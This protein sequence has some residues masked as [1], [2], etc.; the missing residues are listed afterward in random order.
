MI[1]YITLLCFLFVSNI[2]VAQNDSMYHNIA[3][4]AIENLNVYQ[5]SSSF[6][7]ESKIDDFY[8]LF[9]NNQVQVVNDILHLNEANSSISLKEYINIIRRNYKR[10]NVSISINEIGQIEYSNESSGTFDVYVTKEI[11]GENINR[12]YQVLI[13]D[14]TDEYDERILY[15]KKL[16]LVFTFHFNKDKMEIIKISN[17]QKVNPT[18]IILP[19][20]RY[21]IF[22]KKYNTEDL[23]VLVDSDT[24]L[25]QGLFHSLDLNK[26]T[27][28]ITPVHD[29]LFGK[30]TVKQAE[31]LRS[32]NKVRELIFK[33]SSIESSNIFGYNFNPIKVFSESINLNLQNNNSYSI[34]S[35][36]RFNLTNILMSKSRF[37]SI[38]ID[39]KPVS[40]ISVFLD[41]GYKL[42]FFSHQITVDNYDYSYMS[43]DD[44][45]A[46]YLRLININSLVEQQEIE[47]SSMEASVLLKYKY[48]KFNFLVGAGLGNVTVDKANF[49]SIASINYSGYYEDFYGLIIAENGVYDFGAYQVEQSGGIDSYKSIQTNSFKFNVEYE[50]NKRLFVN[51]GINYQTSKSGYFKKNNINPSESYLN[52]NTIANNIDYTLNYFS[53]SVGLIIK[54]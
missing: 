13:N 19:K 39:G 30:R 48:E 8:D 12:D 52:L 35:S 15:K 31:I 36:I 43:T 49:S 47:T 28:K 40:P 3:Q 27:I 33:K 25:M 53:T 34:K 16:D 45:G 54:L 20:I 23:K 42:D 26:S 37:N 5:S 38:I 2:I 29:L 44:D 24:T 21:S 51:L 41:F 14:L 1:R 4:L 10:L 22:S 50:C 6:S 18:I 11:N 7:R 46:N 9:K 32:T 17:N